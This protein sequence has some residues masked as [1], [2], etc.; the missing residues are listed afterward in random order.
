M[1]KV[2]IAGCGLVSQY[3]NEGSILLER[4]MKKNGWADSQRMVKL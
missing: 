3:G 4:L 1:K 2:A